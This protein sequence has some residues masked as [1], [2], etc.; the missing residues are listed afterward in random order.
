MLE[1]RE[2]A[3]ISELAVREGIAPSYTTRVL[4]LTLIAPDIVEA[5]LGG[6]QGPELTLARVLEPFPL[7]WEHQAMHFGSA[8]SSHQRA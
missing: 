6:E 1:S 3:T 4:Q 5:N 8:P 7:E 2:F